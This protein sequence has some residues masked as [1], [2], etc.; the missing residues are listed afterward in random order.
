ME[1]KRNLTLF[2]AFFCERKS[3]S[4]KKKNSSVSAQLQ[5]Y[6]Y[7]NLFERDSQFFQ[8]RDFLRQSSLLMS[9]IFYP[10]R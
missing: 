6:K 8:Y 4:R 10:R 5:N 2:R 7:T 3:F 1:D 9:F